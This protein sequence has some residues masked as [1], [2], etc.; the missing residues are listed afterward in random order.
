MLTH[1]DKHRLVEIQVGIPAAGTAALALEMQNIRR[2]RV[3]VLAAGNLRPETQ[4]QVLA[5]HEK[6]FVE[7]AE[8]FVQVATHAEERATDGIHLGHFVRVGIRHVVACKGLVLRE[9]SGKTNRLRNGRDNRRERTSASPLERAILVQNAAADSTRF[10][11]FF[12]EVEHLGK[13]IVGNDRIGID[14]EQ[15]GLGCTLFGEVAALSKAEVFLGINPFHFGEELPDFGQNR[16][17]RA[18]IKHNNLRIDPLACIA[19]GLQACGNEIARIIGNNDNG[20]RVHNN[21][22]FGVQISEFGIKKFQI[23][24]ASPRRSLRTRKNASEIMPPLILEVPRV[25]SVNTMGISLTRRPFF[26][27]LKVVSIWKQ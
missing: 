27:I 14:K 4:V 10:R 12:H 13:G 6:V 9:E 3:V 25:R 2:R 20:T 5:V 18:I 8:F 1:K 15:V 26:Q 19:N 24:H 16:L 7:T 23:H 22:E 17:D 11:V 21:S